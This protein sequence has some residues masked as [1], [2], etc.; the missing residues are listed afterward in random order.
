MATQENQIKT[1]E[2]LIAAK[3]KLIEAQAKQIATLMARIETLER[4]LGLNSSNSSLPPS[5]DEF[6]KPAPKSLRVSSKPFGGQKGHQGGTLKQVENPDK[7]IQLPIHK[8]ITCKKDL[9]LQSSQ[10]PGP[11]QERLFIL[12]KRY[13]NSTIS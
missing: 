4:R 9:S 12:E 8:C 6:F 10:P 1:L 7:V 3:D 5:S 2:A 11:P 13:K